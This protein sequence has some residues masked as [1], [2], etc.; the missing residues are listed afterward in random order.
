MHYII[1]WAV[2]VFASNQW[3]NACTSKAKATFQK[4]GT[5]GYF[6]T[7]GQKQQKKCNTT[8]AVI[9]QYSAWYLAGTCSF[10]QS[11]LRIQEY[12]A[13]LV[14]LMLPFT[15][16]LQML[17]IFRQIFSWRPL[18]KI[19]MYGCQ[20]VGL[21]LNELS[22]NTPLQLTGRSFFYY[23]SITVGTSCIRLLCARL[24]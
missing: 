21:S 20:A 10:M 18:H 17:L 11:W 9:I 5:E 14:G 4:F 8:N 12:N 6:Q 15:I 13:L 3:L 24:T 22:C 19:C 23:L 2:N 1:Q 16:P 7:L